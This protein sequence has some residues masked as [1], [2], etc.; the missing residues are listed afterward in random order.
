MEFNSLKCKVLHIG[1][2]NPEHDYYMRGVKLQDVDCEK[3][4]GVHI[5]KTLKLTEQ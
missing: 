4:I 3:D 5:T 2:N 1:R